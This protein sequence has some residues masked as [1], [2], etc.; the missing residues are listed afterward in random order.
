MEDFRKSIKEIL[1]ERTTSPLYGTF[2]ISW[3]IWNW[4]I[5]YIT[6]FVSEKQIG[7]DKLTYIDTNLI[8]MNNIIWFPILS[9]IVLL[10]IFPF[11]SN[12]AYWL[13]LIFKRWRNDKKNKVE[14]KQLL[15][16]EQSI[17]M[18]KQITEQENYYERI[19]SDKDLKIKQSESLLK[20]AQTASTRSEESAHSL[21]VLLTEK[22]LQIEELK[23]NLRNLP[24]NN[25]KLL[26]DK[27]LKIKQLEVALQT[28]KEKLNNK[29]LWHLPLNDLENYKEDLSYERSLQFDNGRRII[30]IK[31]D[32]RNKVDYY[33]DADTNEEV[34][35]IEMN[36]LLKG[37]YLEVKTKEHFGQSFNDL[38]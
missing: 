4:K 35:F 6:L 33:V 3:L 10:L 22:D 13:S 14:S 27:D 18:R 19:V 32:D 7:L 2:I 23:N 12:G 31:Y 11:I 29:E 9:T 15:T 25:E 37:P 8:S 28:E 24:E 34:G 17:S 5:V 20:E 26:S 30:Y 38:L 36:D 16:M 1:Y 21:L